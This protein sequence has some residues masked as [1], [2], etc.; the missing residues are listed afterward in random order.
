[1]AAA[2]VTADMHH[3]RPMMTMT[4]IPLVMVMV[5]IVTLVIANDVPV[6]LHG[7][8]VNTL[9]GGEIAMG[10]YAGKLLLVVNVARYIMPYH[11]TL[12]NQPS[13]SF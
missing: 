11:S 1:M 6:S 9:Q 12:I 13:S 3:R 7:I 5:T 4:M 10:N 2:A 8:V